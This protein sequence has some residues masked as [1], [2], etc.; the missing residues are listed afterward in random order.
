M[1]RRGERYVGVQTGGE[2]NKISL[3]AVNKQVQVE[4][5]P[6]KFARPPSGVRKR[7]RL[8]HARVLIKLFT[9]QHRVCVDS[10]GSSSSTTTTAVA[11]L[12]RR[13][14]I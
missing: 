5:E 3:K 12:N 1:A 9:G 6:P 2:E 13:Q 8:I 11:K 7:E 4:H 14:I 10:C